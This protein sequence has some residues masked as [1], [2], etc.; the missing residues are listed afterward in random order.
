MTDR[1]ILIRTWVWRL[2]K[3]GAAIAVVGGAAFWLLWSP[4]PVVAHQA[5]RA[6]IVA[7][8]MGTGTLEARVKATISPKING[9]I[10]EIRVDQGDRVTAGQL[11]VRLDDDELTR[12]VEIARA[13]QA[14]AEAAIDRVKT[15][16]QRTLAI[17]AQAEQHYERTAGLRQTNAVSA[18]DFDRAREALAVAQA[19]LANA[20]ATI[21]EAQKDLVSAEKTL[22]FHQAR[23]AD[24]RISAPFDGLIVA[25]RRDPGD[26]VV[27]GSAILTL[28][29]TDQLWVSAW[30]DETEMAK[31]APDQ[32]ARVAFRSEPEKSYPG[33]VA[34]LGRETDRETREFIVDVTVLELPAN[35]AV[36]QRAD[37][38]IETA[39]EDSAVIIP[40]AFVA[41]Q[42][43][44]GT[45]GADTK[46]PGVFV[47][48]AARARWVPVA[49][50][51]RSGAAVQVV[52]GLSAGDRVIIPANEKATLN[53]G[54]RVELP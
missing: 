10:A 14:S 23:L 22:Q 8:V 49:L 35:W 53:D 31:L 6:G 51:L 34:R 39:R 33:K 4:I 30:V 41:W 5:K 3:L 45:T 27:P 19:G 17:L 46:S 36:G 12:Q 43:G 52:E 24:T 11:L 21:A 42:D 38:F 50:G 15:D 1:W 20:E 32:P 28:I 2:A 13:N 25:R 44:R 48:D 18:D 16:K 47:S 37:V 9:R 40:P 54:D 7:E 26:V 29:S